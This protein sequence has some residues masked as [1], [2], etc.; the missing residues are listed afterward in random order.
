MQIVTRWLTDKGDY[1]IGPDGACI[2]DPTVRT[3]AL[4]RL[5]TRRGKYWADPTMGSR[6]WERHSLE[7]ARAHAL[8]DSLE[9]LKPL[10]DTGEIL[11][12]E[13]GPDGVYQD[14]DGTI[15]FQLLVRVDEETIITLSALPIGT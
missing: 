9:A 1:Q 15:A 12:V 11:A 10:L 4:V 13:L 3:R 5:R 14:A 8:S 7:D 6:L 2:E